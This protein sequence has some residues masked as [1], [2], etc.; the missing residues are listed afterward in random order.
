[1]AT[2]NKKTKLKEPV[3]IRTKK[4]ADGS[5]SYYLDIY[6]DGK[7]SYE[8][9][10]LYRLPEINA[11]VKEQNKATLA[12]V[13]TI[14]S[15]RIIELTH[16]KAGLKNTSTRSKMLLTDWMQTF[17]DDQKRRGVRGVKLLGTVSRLIST[18]IV[19]NKVRMG[20][21]DKEFCIGFI[22][23]LQSDYKTAWGNPLSPKSMSDY[24]GYFSTALNA[25]VRADIIPENPFMSL[26]PTER[27]KVPESK[28]EFLTVDEIKTLIAT[29]CPREDVKRAYLFACYCGLRLSDVYALKWKDLSQDGEQW[30]AS[31][32]MQK[33]T[34]PIF[35]P[36]SGQAVKWLPERGEA[37][38]DENV[39]EGLI[40][41]PNINKVLAKWT[42]AAG[43]TKK[44]TY[45][46]SRHT[47]ATMMLTLGADLY[48]TS[49]LLG[50][51]NVKTTQIYA[52]IVDSK[53]VEAVNL[54]D[55]VFD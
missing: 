6:A 31:V 53:K 35:L 24:V 9:L 38:D 4:L 32:V 22:R 49:K 43:I 19:K 11:R 26:T 54:V 23:W 36:L 47:F 25:A 16:N 46:T 55:N 2:T 50:H 52:K 41:E 39:F 37:K 33:T 18:Y 13:E 17:Y 1:M 51:S 14:K 8:F 3:R 29:E 40:A 12:A 45:H 42:K 44:I 15:Q 7:R 20:D 34:T 10:K 28:R 21:I 27:I 30:R 48:T 5:E